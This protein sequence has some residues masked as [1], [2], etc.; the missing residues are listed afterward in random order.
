M[1]LTPEQQALLA[2]LQDIQLPD[3]VG[4]WPPS[5]FLLVMLFSVGGML[6]WLLWFKWQAYQNNRYRQQAQHLLSQALQH[7][8]TPQAKVAAINAVLKQVAITHYGRNETA[9]LT[10][11]AWVQFLQTSANYI[12][13][14]PHL[15]ATLQA[16]YQG[17][18]SAQQVQTFLDYALA[19]I[20][21]HHK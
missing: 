12:A 8:D 10:G 16:S 17:Q 14:P 1:N 21:G 6:M 13:Q 9:A 7:A 3:A 19:W 11:E 2:Q 4:W 5:H 20:K 15:A 18:V